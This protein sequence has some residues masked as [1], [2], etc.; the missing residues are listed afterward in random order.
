MNSLTFQFFTAIPDCSS[1]GYPSLG[2]LELFDSEQSLFYALVAT[3]V[4]QNICLQKNVYLN[5][6]RITGDAPGLGAPR[7]CTDSGAYCPVNSIEQGLCPA[8][9]AC[10]DAGSIRECELTE[11]CEVG[12]TSFS[13]CPSGSYCP[14]TTVQIT[15]PKGSFCPE[16]VVEPSACIKGHYCKFH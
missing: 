12:T 5:F 1:E 3:P 8:G 16:G 13:K 14:N 9:Y 11:F 4:T 2:F 15:C 6:F 10:S 7:K